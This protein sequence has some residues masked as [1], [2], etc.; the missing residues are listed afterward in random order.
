MAHGKTSRSGSSQKTPRGGTGQEGEGLPGRPFSLP[1]GYYELYGI[2]PP[3]PE[4]SP[5]HRVG[6]RPG[7]SLPRGLLEYYGMVAREPAAPGVVQRKEAPKERAAAAPSL[8]YFAEGARVVV[9]PKPDQATPETVR[10]AFRR[11]GVKDPPPGPQEVAPSHRTW[12]LFY[13]LYIDQQGQGGKVDWHMLGQVVGDMVR[14]GGF[15]EAPALPA[16]VRRVPEVAP[17]QMQPGPW[18]PHGD[19]PLPLYIGNQ[20]HIAIAAYYSNLHYKEDVQTNSIPLFSILKRLLKNGVEGIDPTALGAEGALRPD[21]LNVTR[22]L[23]YEIKPQESQALAAA[24]VLIYIA[25]LARAGL[26]VTLGPST[27]PGTS[28]ILPAPA[29]YF[30]FWSPMPGVIVY[31]YTKKPPEPVAVPKKEPEVE[32]QFDL[33]RLWEWKYWEDVTGLTGTALVVYLIISEG[34]RLYPPRN[35]LALP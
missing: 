33:R 14:S 27:E 23:I 13:A 10:E 17:G 18:S 24:E 1:P 25:A 12:P 5:A 35:A 4:R 34:S 8:L 2:R 26:V 20:A 21:I 19:E 9:V 28:G 15:G 30:R 6:L 22:R 3:E 32:P 29:G 7:R 16:D 11:A 31:Q